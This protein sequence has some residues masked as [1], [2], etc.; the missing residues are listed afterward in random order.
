MVQTHYQLINTLQLTQEE[1]EELVKPSLEYAA[2]I[3]TD[4]AVLRH[5]IGY[6]YS[7]P[8]DEYYNKAISSKND[9]VYKML[10]I[11]DKFAKTKIYQQFR[12]DLIKSFIK[13]LRC[14]HILVNGNYSTLCGNPIEMLR[15]AI[16]I[17]D[18][19]SCIDI[20]TIHSTKFENGVS[21]LGSRSPHV[22]MGNILITKNVQRQEIFDYMNSTPEIVYVNS[23]KDNLLERLSG[24][25]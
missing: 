8:D 11:T 1:V 4:P 22:T 7:T 6:Q 9:I 15:Q 20:G 12:D 13:N 17:F 21:I 23:I 24:A 14:G 18:G 2:M 3:K 19:K 5:Q 10:G 16:G 25:D